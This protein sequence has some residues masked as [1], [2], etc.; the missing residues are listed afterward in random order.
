[1][2]DFHGHCCNQFVDDP[3]VLVNQKGFR[4]SVNSPVDADPSVCIDHRCRIGIAQLRQPLP[5]Q[6][7]IVFPVETVNGNDI[8]A[9]DFQQRVMFVET[10]GTP[11]S[12]DIEQIYLPE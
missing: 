9:L 1:M 6:A 7:R 5:G 8:L 4:G 11:C 12:P 3:A 2:T 10:G